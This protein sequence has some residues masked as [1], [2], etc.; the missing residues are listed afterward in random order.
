M[1][2]KMELKAPNLFHKQNS[3]E[4]LVMVKHALFAALTFAFILALCLS[5]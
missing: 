4:M 2:L 5:N 1:D 3:S